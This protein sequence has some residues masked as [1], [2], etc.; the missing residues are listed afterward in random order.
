[1]AKKILN[2][3][4]FILLYGFPGAGKTFFS[5]QL[6][7]ELQLAHIQD[8]RIRHKL[9]EQPR[10]DKQENDIV[11]QL[12]TYMAE[13]FLRAGMSVIYDT[14]ASRLSH[15]RI[16][17]DFARHLKAQPILI[18]LQIDPE[19]AYNRVASRDRRKTDDKYASPLDGN[20]FEHIIQGMQNPTNTED[21]IVLSGKHTFATQK[22]MFMKKIYDL[23]LISPDT[24]SSKVV[25]PGLVNLVPSPQP[26]RVDQSRRNIIIR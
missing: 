22:N 4:A 5:R 25:K 6:C 10:Y 12:M 17:R 21:Y 7:E 20:T 18:W 23:N 11:Q 8:D 24:T 13:E 19:T 14:N 3:P 2:R 16:M 1:M 9:F 15:R 26:G